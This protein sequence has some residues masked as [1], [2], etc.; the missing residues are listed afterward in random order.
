MPEEPARRIVDTDAIDTQAGEVTSYWIASGTI[1]SDEHS[2][3]LRRALAEVVREMEGI[4]AG[5]EIAD[6][7]AP[8]PVPVAG[9]RQTCGRCDL[10][11][12]QPPIGGAELNRRRAL[13]GD[14]ATDTIPGRL[15]LR[16]TTA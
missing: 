11:S 7:V 3:E 4:L 8:V 14:E 12:Q 5:F 13:T 15:R 10:D 2:A 9:D 16:S 6:R 1:P